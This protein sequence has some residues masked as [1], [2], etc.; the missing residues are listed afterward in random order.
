MLIGHGGLVEEVFQRGLVRSVSK[1]TWFFI[2][3]CTFNRLKH[4]IVRKTKR[5]YNQSGHPW[6]SGPD[7]R[8]LETLTESF[9]MAD[10][11]KR[12]ER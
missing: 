6:R 3:V 2:T 5:P 4:F 1:Q 10:E 8:V 7:Q 9:S 12:P 11:K